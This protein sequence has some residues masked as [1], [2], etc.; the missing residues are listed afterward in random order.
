MFRIVYIEKV[1]PK[2]VYSGNTTLYICVH[3]QYM[4]DFSSHR[5]GKW[6]P[7]DRQY[8]PQCYAKWLDFSIYFLNKFPLK[9]SFTKDNAYISYSEWHK[10]SHHLSMPHKFLRKLMFVDVDVCWCMDCGWLVDLSNDRRSQCNP[11]H[12]LDSLYSR[13][14]LISRGYQ[15]QNASGSRHLLQRDRGGT[16]TTDNFL[17]SWRE[18]FNNVPSILTNRS[19]HNK[20][21]KY[22]KTNKNNLSDNRKHSLSEDV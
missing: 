2:R 9:F 7:Y 3:V 14:L 11:D 1:T 18:Y 4:Y 16:K 20:V 12:G 6:K 15:L 21:K 8:A 19:K 13:L 17:C 5:R 22:R 10:N